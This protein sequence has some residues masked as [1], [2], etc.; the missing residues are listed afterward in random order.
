MNCHG[1]LQKHW[2]DTLQSIS[3]IF[4][5]I[6]VGV[7]S[8]LIH[9]YQQKQEEKLLPRKVKTRILNYTKCWLFRT[10]F[11]AGR[12][13][14][15]Q[16]QESVSNKNWLPWGFCWIFSTAATFSVWLKSISQDWMVGEKLTWGS[17]CVGK[18]QLKPHPLRGML[19]SEKPSLLSPMTLVI[20]PVLW[21]AVST[22]NTKSLIFL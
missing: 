8:F 17:I 21:Q 22:P 18:K 1:K 5:R 2:L 16:I 19:H 14:S 6:P 7:F 3:C 20:P 15:L 11:S 10:H 12:T 9:N 13:H 4:Y